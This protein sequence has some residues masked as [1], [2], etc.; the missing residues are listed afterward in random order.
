MNTRIGLCEVGFGRGGVACE[1]FENIHE[2]EEKKTVLIV[3]V[4]TP[5]AVQPWLNHGRTLG[6]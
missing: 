2:R 4:S 3:K 5:L 1:M 6:K